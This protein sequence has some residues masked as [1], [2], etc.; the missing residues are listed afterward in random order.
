MY[1]YCR[2]SNVPTI[3]SYHCKIRAQTESGSLAV[4]REMLRYAIW[5]DVPAARFGRCVCFAYKT[6]NH[7]SNINNSNKTHTHIHW[8]FSAYYSLM[9]ALFFP[10]MRLCSGVHRFPWNSLLFCWPRCSHRCCCCCFFCFHFAIRFVWFV[11]AELY[12]LCSF[13]HTHIS[14]ALHFYYI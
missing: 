1:A 4:K 3:A 2:R 6:E 11:H 8:L 10:H 5:L 13:C 14:C 7:S 9:N 12:L